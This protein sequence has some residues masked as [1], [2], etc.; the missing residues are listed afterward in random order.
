[1]PFY[2]EVVLV[3]ILNREN[4]LLVWFVATLGNTLG[5]AVNWVLGK[6]LTRFEDKRWFPFKTKN[7]HKAQQGFQ[8]YGVW[9]LLL[10]W[11]PIGG[12]AITFVAGVMRVRFL[13]FFVLTGIGKGL[14]YLVVILL[15]FG[16]V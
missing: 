7:L 12:D 6:Y 1:L 11:L 14:R 15:F 4:A 3:S 8:K 10:A 16:L 2:S 5:S 13:T 9:S